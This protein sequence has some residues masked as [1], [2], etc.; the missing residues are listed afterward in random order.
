MHRKFHGREALGLI[1]Q[2]VDSY[3]VLRAR[4]LREGGN[5][6]GRLFAA[7]HTASNSSGPFKPPKGPVSTS[8]GDS[9]GGIR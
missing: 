2:H 7:G 6:R 5:S 9:E 3:R 4:A 8:V 1:I